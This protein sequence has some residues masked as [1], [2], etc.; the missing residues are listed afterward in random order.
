MGAAGSRVGGRRVGAA[1]ALAGG[2]AALS[3]FGAAGCD[4][5]KFAEESKKTPVRS[6]GAPGQFKA[7]DFGRAILPLSDGQGTAAAF[8][9]S[10]INETNVA[11]ITM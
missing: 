6:I 10:S 8:V 7:G 1:V 5:R 4:W 2:L 11:I 3:A 9:G